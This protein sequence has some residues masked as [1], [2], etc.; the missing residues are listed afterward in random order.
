MV[1]RLHECVRLDV[2]QYSGTLVN[3]DKSSA[4]WLRDEMSFRGLLRGS[5]GL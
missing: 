2:P 5:M 1:F 4:T 3:V